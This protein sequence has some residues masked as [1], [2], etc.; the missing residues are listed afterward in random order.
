MN[1][2]LRHLRRWVMKKPR[3]ET[4]DRVYQRGLDYIRSLRDRHVLDL[5]SENKRLRDYITHLCKNIK[6]VKI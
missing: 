4:P 6:E 5:E 3:P 2:I 1:R